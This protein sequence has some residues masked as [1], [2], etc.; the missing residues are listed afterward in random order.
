MIFERA[1][2][3]CWKYNRMMD[4]MER[5]CVWAALIGLVGLA[6]AAFFR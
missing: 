4:S 1:A 2:F 5:F 3:G 6:V